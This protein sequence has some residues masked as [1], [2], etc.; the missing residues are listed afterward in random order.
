MAEF[1]G[2]R[3]WNAWNVSLWINNT[4]RLY[5]AARDI[6]QEKARKYGNTDRARRAAATAILAMIGEN[7]QTPDGARY[8]YRCVYDAI[9][10]MID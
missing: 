2:F 6:Y 5:M 1:N 7:E 8:N 9:E 3:S 4:E 10:G